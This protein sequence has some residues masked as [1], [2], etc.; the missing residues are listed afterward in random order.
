M[1]CVEANVIG[2]AWWWFELGVLFILPACKQ[3]RCKLNDLAFFVSA[4]TEYWKN[5]GRN[6]EEMVVRLVAI[7]ENYLR[8]KFN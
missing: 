4:K 5:L 3:P 8:N 2:G 7:F 6:I 1:A